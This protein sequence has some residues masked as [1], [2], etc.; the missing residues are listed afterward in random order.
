ML[1]GFSDAEDAK[2]HGLANQLRVPK[3]NISVSV[4]IEFE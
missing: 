3:I 4:D 1:I 2:K